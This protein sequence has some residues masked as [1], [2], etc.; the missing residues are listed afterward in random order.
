MPEHLELLDWLALDFMAHGW[1]QKHLL[2]TILT[3][4]VYRQSS[5]ATP[6]LLERDPR[7]RLLARGPRFRLDAEVI[8]DSALSIA[9]L[10]NPAVGGPSIFPPVPQ[11]VLDFNF[12]KPTYWSPAE[13][14]DRYR[15]ALYMFRKRSMPDPVMGAFDSPNGDTAC[16]RRPRSNTPLAALTSLNEPVFVEAAQGLALRVLR[17][18]GATEAERA[19][20]AYRLCT[21]RPIKPVER[22]TVFALLRETRQRLADG[23]LN[24]GEIATGDP[25]KL[26]A[27]AP[28]TVPSDAAAWTVVARVLLNLD[29]TVT[30]F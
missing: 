5:H 22:E 4:A 1:S 28:G 26:P 30:K 7:N 23:W 10:L 19:D 9:E 25:G 18:G 13:G 17:E 6:E 29:E 12:V 16:V 14:P 20:F 24:A 11:S 21:G 3:S 15:R 2:R 27:L 8:R